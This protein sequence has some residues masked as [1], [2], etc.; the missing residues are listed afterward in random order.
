MVRV[1][2][3]DDAQLQ[4]TIIRATNS[5][6]R[7]AASSLRMTDQIHRNIEEFFKKFDLFYDRRKGF[8]KDQARPITKIVSANDIVQAIVSILIQKPNDARARPGDYF[9]DEASYAKVFAD[10]K[11][12]LEAYLVCVQIVRRVGKYF[13][14]HQ[15]DSSIRRNLKFYVSAFLA[16]DITRM[17]RPVAAKLPAVSVVQSLS[18]NEIEDCLKR[19]KRIFAPLAKSA[20]ADTVA[21]GPE[22]LKRVSIPRQSRGL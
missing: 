15:S 19:I 9:K 4:D 13:E 22:L 5:Q 18:D 3:T 11:I 6:N 17:A 14:T 1:I 10:D 21:R 16:R 8:Y 2:Q 12:T 20:D 7:M